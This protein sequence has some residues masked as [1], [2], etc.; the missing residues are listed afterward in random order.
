VR[1]G[2]VFSALATLSE[3]NEDAPVQLAE[4][5]F[6]QAAEVLQSQMR[7]R[8]IR[9]PLAT[10]VLMKTTLLNPNLARQSRAWNWQSR[11]VTSSSQRVSQR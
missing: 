3:L 10:N 7:E 4:A 2:A 11:R 6:P 5:G 9:N 8:M 1:C